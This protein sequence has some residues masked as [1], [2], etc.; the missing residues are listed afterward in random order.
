MIVL[1]R[2]GNWL[3]APALLIFHALSVS[4]VTQ[5]RSN[6]INDVSDALNRFRGESFAAV[7]FADKV[8][9]HPL[10]TFATNDQERIEKLNRRFEHEI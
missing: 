5:L 9:K 3:I 2:A 6:V 7:S 4:R 8:L 10:L 1:Q